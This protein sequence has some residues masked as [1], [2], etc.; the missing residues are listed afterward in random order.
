MLGGMYDESVSGDNPQQQLVEI[1]ETLISSFYN[2]PWQRHCISLFC[3]D[4]TMTRCV[5]KVGKE[6][7]AQ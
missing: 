1:F 6:P 3:L 4:S 5:G 7:P 2:L